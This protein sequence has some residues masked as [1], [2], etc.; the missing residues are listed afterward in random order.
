MTLVPAALLC[1]ALLSPQAQP[2]DQRADAERLARAGEYS[3]ALKQFQAIAAANPDDVA[4]R[5]WIARLHVLMGNPA[6]AVDVYESIVATDPNNV[7]ALVGLGNALVAIRRLDAAGDAL[8]RAEAIAA[9]RPAVLAGQG[10]LHRIAGRTTLALAYYQRALALDPGNAE[11]RDDYDD[12]R[13]ARAHRLGGTYYFESFDVDVPDTHAGYVELNARVTDA[14]R[15]FAA[16][17]HQRKFSEDETRGGGGFEWLPRGNV[18]VRAGAMFGEDTFLLPDG[19]GALDASYQHG[20]LGL[21]GSIRY[22]HFEGASSV[23]VSPGASC[24]LTDALSLE[25]RYFRSQADF[26]GAS[27]GEGNNGVSVGVIAR[28]ARRA[29]V[30]A[31]YAR[32]YESHPVITVEQL[33]ELD[34]DTVSG[35]VRVDPGAMTSVAATYQYEWR[36]E[37]VRVGTLFLNLTQRF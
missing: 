36:N 9:D 34:A 14:F 27:E 19:E 21:L 1:L 31:R 28:A 23:I 12:A 33:L 24:S 6:R 17:Q 18:R 13:A 4:A 15:L 29:W 32:G 7:D 37:G 35:S 11:A 25:F 3:R 5:T 26:R 30:S 2:P 20:R 22:L 10:R 16:G 8:N